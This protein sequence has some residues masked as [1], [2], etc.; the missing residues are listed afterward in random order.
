MSAAPAI[1]ARLAAMGAWIE[2]RG[3]RVVVRAGRRPVPVALI[4]EARAAKA[5]LSKVLSAIE[6]AQVGNDE[7]LRP[8]R[9]SRGAGTLGA[10]KDAQMSTFDEHLQ[11]VERALDVEDAHPVEPMS[12]F[13]ET[14][15]FR[16]SP[17]VPPSKML[18]PPSLSI[19]D[20]DEHLRVPPSPA[21]VSRVT[22]KSRVA[23]MWRHGVPRAWVEG[24][25]LLDPDRPPGDVPSK[26][27]RTFIVD[28]GRFFDGGWGE[29]A[30]ALGW[31]PIDLFGCD[32]DR[33]F[34]RI[35][36]AGLLWLLHGERVVALTQE[37]AVIETASGARQ[38]YRRKPDTPGRV[39][40]WQ[41]AATRNNLKNS[42][43][44]GCGRV[45]C[46]AS[47]PA[48]NDLAADRR[49]RT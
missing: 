48:P 26:H 8:S 29:K 15:D 14:P 46:M 2:C 20:D 39:L 35:D 36:A 6:D 17:R 33:P 41:L 12:T 47:E 23:F 16:G 7:H 21:V 28:V 22:R 30:A 32:D 10:V 9:P 18:I 1:L 45:P 42:D 4:A 34:A 38:T 11:G 43:L 25:A 19:L 40:P 44:C 31:G 37:A 13:D 24:L 49:G 5:E 27:W 3:D